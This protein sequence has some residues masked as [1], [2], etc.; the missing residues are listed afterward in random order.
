MKER[1]APRILKREMFLLVALALL[2]VGVFVFTKRM[3]VREQHMEA[4]IARIRYQ[5]GKQ[6]LSSGKLEEAIQSFRGATADERENKQYALALADAV[7]KAI[8][9]PRRIRDAVH[10]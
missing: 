7:A 5:R 2:A 10:H 8:T 9:I 3:A 1:E 4:W 6:Q